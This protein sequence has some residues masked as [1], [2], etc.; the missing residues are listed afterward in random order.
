[1]KKFSEE[2]RAAVHRQIDALLDTDGVDGIMVTAAVFHDDAVKTFQF[3][4]GTVSAD[5]Q[6]LTNLN[7]MIDR[8]K[9]LGTLN[10]LL[11]I[12]PLLDCV[13]RLRKL[14]DLNEKSEEAGHA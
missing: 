12:N 7:M 1:M 11:M 6:I 8:C 10:A 3:G 13:M 14:H 4:K 2:D 9:Q 5:D